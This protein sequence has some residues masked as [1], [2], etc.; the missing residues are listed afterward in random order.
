MRESELKIIKGN[1][2]LIVCFGGFALKIGG[3]LPFEFFKYLSSVYKDEF[4]MIFFIDKRRCV[5]HNGLYG[6]TKNVDDTVRY[7][8]QFTN[9]YKNIIFMGV[10]AGGYSAILF[11]S[12]CQNVTHVIGF[13]PPTIIRKPVNP[14]YSNL[15]SI[16]NDKTQY[17]L[18]G[19]LNVEDVNDPHHISHC[20]NIEEFTNVTVLRMK[21]VDL[22]QLKNEGVI[23]QTIDNIIFN[24]N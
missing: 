3:I 4:D 19:D 13:I 24:E 23:K 10:S 16:I 2:N 17:I 14:K 11:G 22:K 6:I 7:I 15:K 1:K 9:N 20:E 8:N 5:Y 12:L 21:G 18:F